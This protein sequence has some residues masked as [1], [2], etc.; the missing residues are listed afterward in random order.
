MEKRFKFSTTEVA[1]I[2]FEPKGQALYRDSEQPGLLVIAGTRSKSYVVQIEKPVAMGQRRSTRKTLGRTDAMTSQQARQAARALIGGLATGT[3]EVAARN[4][5]LTLAAAWAVYR[6]SLIVEG[7]AARTV[8]QYQS[9]IDGPLS[10]FA[11][12][13]L[14]ELSRNRAEVKK[15]H[16]EIG[17][18][19]GHK[20]KA[21][22]AAKLLRAV[23]NQ[24]VRE[25][26][27][28][29]LPPVNPVSFKMFKLE[30]RSCALAPSDLPK[31][32]EQR[33]KLEPVRAAFHMFLLLTA[34]RPTCAKQLRWD[35][36]DFDQEF[37]RFPKAVVKGSRHDLDIPISSAVKACLVEAR[38]AGLKMFPRYAS[39]F[40]FPADSRSGHLAFHQEKPAKLSHFGGALRQT[41]RSVA[42]IVGLGTIEVHLLMGHALQ[43]V[44]ANYNDKSALTMLLREASE[45][46]GNYFSK[47]VL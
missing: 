43:G 39:T 1:K 31:W 33:L 20:T 28:D 30:R 14:R 6:E 12:V 11:K 3:V 26:I 34:L 27:E 22:G 23:Y 44:N 21:N 38:E 41:W 19:E 18:K 47:G 5:R 7:K 8:E 42:T 2:P 35:W 36:I 16:F 40:V 4:G 45:K 10:R 17:T 25:G 32:N 37:I 9:L 13:P 29:D 15:W 24:A 46:V